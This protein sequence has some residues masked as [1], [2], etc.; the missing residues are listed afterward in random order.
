MSHHG[1]GLFLPFASL[2]YRVMYSRHLP[3]PPK[4]E[5]ER[6]SGYV[7]LSAIER[8][9]ERMDLASRVYVMDQDRVIVVP[10]WLR[11][12]FEKAVSAHSGAV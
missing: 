2:G 12:Q 4:P 11:H 10:S 8:N 6:G 3:P 7:N 5:R 9:R 1:A